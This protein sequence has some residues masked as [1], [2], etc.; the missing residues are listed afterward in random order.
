M[1]FKALSN[2][3]NWLDSTQ[4]IDGCVGEPKTT[5]G[6]LI[7]GGAHLS[8]LRGGWGN[9]GLVGSDAVSIRSS[10]GGQW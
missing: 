8:V 7:T 3:I 9:A 6:P 10:G 5:P 2:T 4:M 1:C